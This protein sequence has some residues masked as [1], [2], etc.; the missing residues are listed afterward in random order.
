MQGIYVFGSPRVGNNR[1]KNRMESIFPNGKLQRF[2]FMDDPV[3]NI[4]L[5][6]FHGY[7]SA[8]FRNKFRNICDL[9]FDTGEITN[10]NMWT[11]GGGTILSALHAGLTGTGNMCFHH[12]EW[13]VSASYFQIKQNHGNLI[14]RLPNNILMPNSDDYACG[15][16]QCNEAK[17][18]I[19]C[20]K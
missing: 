9:N 11:D 18:G 20:N 2:E 6:D 4:P 8:G 5:R 10:D 16:N 1:F 17:E 15:V 14:S 3:C 19:P 7:R 12:P 13:Y